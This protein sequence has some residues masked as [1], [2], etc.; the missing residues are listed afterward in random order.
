M[1]QFTDK[2]IMKMILEKIKSINPSVVIGEQMPGPTAVG[3][4]GKIIVQDEK[5]IP[6]KNEIKMT[7]QPD[8]NM[9]KGHQPRM[10][11]S[12]S[13]IKLTIRGLET[14]DEETVK[15]LSL[16]LQGHSAYVY[17][18]MV[19]IPNRE[20]LEKYEVGDLVSFAKMDSETFQPIYIETRLTQEMIDA[21]SEVL[22]RFALSLK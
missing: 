1:I 19:T 3:C 15:K 11:L 22:F 17:P 2:A 9:V 4:V 18:Y 16:N 14:M 20:W 12:S 8:V 5:P 6:P 13:A 7:N 21:N 10:S